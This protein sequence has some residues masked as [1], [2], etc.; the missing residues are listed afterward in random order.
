MTSLFFTPFPIRIVGVATV[1]VLRQLDTYGQVPR[2]SATLA[3]L[4]FLL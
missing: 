2:N 3:V 4:H 1:L